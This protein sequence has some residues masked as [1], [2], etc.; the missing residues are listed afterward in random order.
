MEQVDVAIVG[1]GLSGL[2]AAT[3]LT[4]RGQDVVVLEAQ[5]RVGGRTY[6][7]T[8]AGVTVDGGAAYVGSKQTA[9]L[10]LAKKLGVETYDV[11]TSGESMLVFQGK[12]VAE[13]GVSG[14]AEK[15]PPEDARQ[16]EQL[17][18]ALEALIAT[19]NIEEPWLTPNA[20]HLDALSVDGWATELGITSRAA[21]RVLSMPLITVL[22][23]VASRISALWCAWYF[24]QGGG[25]R[26]LTEMVD[27]A[28]EQKFV[29]GSQS[30]SLKLAERLG[31]RVRLESP[32]RRVT[33][34]DDGSAVLDCGDRQIAAQ[35]VIVACSPSE[36]TKIAFEPGLPEDRQKLN[37]GWH[38]EGTHKPFLAYERPFWRDAGLSGEIWSDGAMGIVLD[39]TPP[40][41]TP[42]LLLA[43]TDETKLPATPEGR[44][45]AIAADLATVLGDEALNVIDYIET[46][47]R[48]NDWI[49]GCVSPLP[50]GFLVD[51]WSTMNDPVGPIHWAGTETARMSCG[52]M[53]GAVRAGQR[54]ANEVSQLLTARS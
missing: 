53:D 42:G 4:E 23:S 14:G 24:A 17:M 41:G 6:N 52:Y 1:G 25:Y 48:E 50:P 20:Q 43:F 39:A 54:A 19:V 40:S 16:F 18:E 36:V 51:V 38:L 3:E 15:L 34:Q 5:D 47:W 46:E 32:V 44:R 26:F 28:Q 12:R 7:R 30:I 13:G 10:A 21:I 8:V 29:G 11:D 49:S 31:E 27:G 2:T 37:E 33:V 35:R 9:V 22:G 45:D